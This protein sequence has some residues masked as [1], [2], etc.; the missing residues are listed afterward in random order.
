MAHRKS[1][2]L[3]CN[4]EKTCDGLNFEQRE[5]TDCDVMEIA[6]YNRL[7]ISQV[8]D[9][10]ANVDAAKN[11][12]NKY[13]LTKQAK[14]MELIKEDPRIDWKTRDVK[15]E[16]SK[17]Y[18]ILIRLTPRLFDQD[19]KT[20]PANELKN[21]KIVKTIPNNSLTRASSKSGPKSPGPSKSCPPNHG[22]HNPHQ[23]N[24]RPP[25]TST[26]NQSSQNFGRTNLSPQNPRQPNL[27]S[28]TV[29]PQSCDQPYVDPQNPCSQTVGPQN[30]RPQNFGPPSP[31]PQN[32][33]RSNID[34]YG[35]PIR[36]I[37]NQNSYDR[38]QIAYQAPPSRNIRRGYPEPMV[39]MGHNAVVSQAVASP[40]APY[41]PYD[42]H[43]ANFINRVADDPQSLPYVLDE[44]FHN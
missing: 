1:Q 13:I 38:S 9:L 5:F 41:M 2:C 15:M 21:D 42:D 29:A 11:E 4:Y 24:C 35:N 27:A 31:R 14:L 30:L 39:Q 18:K 28:P 6:D 26:P 36:Q 17:N 19:R 44:I 37:S 10:Q 43:E 12:A 25:K 7:Q 22:L 8:N 34:R 23:T 20:R 33:G 40:S 32:Y 16:N 3:K